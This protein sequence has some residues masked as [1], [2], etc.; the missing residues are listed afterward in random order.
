MNDSLSITRPHA[1][2]LAILLLSAIS[3][4]TILFT[5]FGDLPEHQRHLAEALDFALCGIFLIDFLVS[6]L[7]APNKLAY[8]KLG[9]IDLLSSIPAL[10]FL[11]W[12]RLFHIIRLI[13]ILH[14]IRNAYHLRSVLTECRGHSALITVGTLCFLSIFVGAA[15]VLLFEVSPESNIHTAGDALW[16]ALVTMATVG[17]GDHFPITA[18]GRLVGAAL[19]ILGISLFGTLTGYVSNW[20]DQP[21]ERDPQPLLE[22]VND[23]KQ[24]V[25]SLNEKITELKNNTQ[26]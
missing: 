5:T 9:W 14:V 11:R 16:W 15:L 7:K 21:E 6:F 2:H 24:E 13:R 26:K 17:Y 8:M 22:A 1:W 25:A 10:P 23:L 20:F 19:I 12:G 18:E 4:L 3:L